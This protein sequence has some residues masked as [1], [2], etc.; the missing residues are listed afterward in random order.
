MVDLM[1][2][3]DRVVAAAGRIMRHAQ[4]AKGRNG[5]HLVFLSLRLND[6][7]RDKFHRLV[8]PDAR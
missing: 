2:T 1:F 8:A 6:H 7:R 5:R 3:I 4:V